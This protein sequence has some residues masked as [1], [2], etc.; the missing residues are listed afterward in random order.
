MFR[1]FIEFYGKWKSLINIFKWKGDLFELV[2]SN[3]EFPL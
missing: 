1:L 3:S 2:I